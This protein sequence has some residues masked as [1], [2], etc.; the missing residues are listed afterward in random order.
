MR[1]AFLAVVFVLSGPPEA[2]VAICSD[3]IVDADEQCD[4]GGFCIGGP[5]AGT[6]CTSE[7]DCVDGGACFGGLDDLREC[8]SD[9]DCRGGACRR[10]R[11]VGG[12]ACAANCTFETDIPVPLVAGF[13]ESNG[14]EISFGTSGVVVFSPFLTVPLPLTGAW[15]LT[16]GHSREQVSPVTIRERGVHFDAIPTSTLSCACLRG[17]ARLTCGGTLLDRDGT[18]STDCGPGDPDAAPCPQHRPCAPVH[19][20]GNS[21]SGFI[22]CGSPGVGIEISHDC[23]ATPDAAEFSPAVSTTELERL[24]APR[25]G[26]T[27]L[28]FAIQLTPV[29]GLCTGTTPDYGPDG[30]LCTDDDPLAQ[31]GTPIAVLLTTGAAVGTVIHAANSEDVLGPIAIDGRAFT[32]NDTDASVD[33]SAGVIGGVFTA[34]DQPSISDIVVP[35][36]FGFDQVTRLPGAIGPTPTPG[37]NDCCQCVAPLSCAASNNG[38]CGACHRVSNAACDDD[39]TCRIL[40]PSPTETLTLPPP[41]TPS[42]PACVGDCDGSREVTVDEIMVLIGIALGQQAV[43][44]CRAADRDGDGTVFV[45]EI[46]AAVQAALAGCAAAE[47]TDRSQ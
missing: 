17:P 38:E 18:L 5:L 1:F 33:I 24:G 41:P 31:R 35:I 9:A 40:T 32:C 19:G 30:I 4:D 26:N 29:V 43:D 3:G 13:V 46:V 2:A 37:P 21:G 14:M 11:P 10:C 45:D 8:V 25:I 7:E 47:T 23:N 36:S 6:V 44:L 28:G 20:P 34:C 42:P 15:T 39:G 27:L 22:D 16:V 12:D